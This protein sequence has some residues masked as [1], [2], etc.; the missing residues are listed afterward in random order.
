MIEFEILNEVK[1][2]AIE[3]GHRI[4]N[5]YDSSYVV[6][7]KSDGSPLTIADRIA[8]NFIC[9]QLRTL[10]PNM[11]LL[12]EESVGIDIEERLIWK[13]FWL[14]D[15]LDGTKE[16]ISRNGEFTVNIAMIEEGHPILGV[17]HAPAKKLTY[18][19]ASE[20]GAWR[21]LEDCV[22]EK[23][24]TKQY[25]GGAARMVSSRSHASKMV[26]RFRRALETRSRQPVQ[27]LAMG[28]S[29]KFCLVAEGRADVY[30]R[31]G[32]TSEWDTG[33]AHCVVEEAGGSI[34]RCDSKRLTYNKCDLRNPWFVAMGDSTYSWLELCPNEHG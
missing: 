26:E 16:F 7:E 23:I 18:F 15:P 17:V 20:Q 10:T 6:E 13:R 4:M 3:V 9:D 11:P 29:L 21:Q 34:L 32:A 2:I 5:L 27:Q 1:R 28:S 24:M 25:H 31:L 14:V 30:P 33:A 12:S 19:A 8:H 22:P